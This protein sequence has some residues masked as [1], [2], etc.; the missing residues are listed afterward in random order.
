MGLLEKLGLRKRRCPACGSER[1]EAGSRT[2]K[3]Y[4]AGYHQPYESTAGWVYG[5]KEVR[6]EF[7][8]CL[9]CGA[10][11]AE[12]RKVVAAHKAPGSRDSKKFGG[13][14]TE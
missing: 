8:K 6:V 5:H 9:D 10:V 12:R 4:V 1:S 7:R 11:Y 2:E 3:E 13:Y 14:G